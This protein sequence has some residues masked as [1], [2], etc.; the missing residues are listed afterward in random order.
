MISKKA[1]EPFYTATSLS[2]ATDVNVLHELKASLDSPGIY[3][4]FEVEDFVAKYFQGLE[5]D[6]YLSPIIQVAEE[7]FNSSLE[8]ENKEKADYKIKASSL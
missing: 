2:G 7:R 5:A 6:T 8:L 1:F 3:E 4:W